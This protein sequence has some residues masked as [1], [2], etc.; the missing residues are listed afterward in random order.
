VTRPESSGTPSGRRTTALASALAAACV[1]L[2]LAGVVLHLIPGELPAGDYGA[3]WLTNSVAAVVIALPGALV[4]ARRP[5]NPLGWLLLGLAFAHGVTVVSREY[6]LHALV[7][8]SGLPFG[9][10]ALWLS[11][12]T[13]IDFPFFLPLFFLFPDGR[14]PSRR[15]A[16]VAAVGMAV[17]LVTTVWL[18]TFPGPMLESGS[19]TILNPLPWHGLARLYENRDTKV[20]WFL[21]A[22]LG[23][24]ILAMLMRA[25]AVVGPARRRIV[26]VALAAAVLA[27]EVGHE[28]LVSYSG[29]EYVAAGVVILFASAVAFAILR[30]GLYEIDFVVSRTVVYGGLT[31]ILGSSYV[32]LVALAGT[33]IHGRALGSLPAAVVVALLFAPVRMRLQRASD[34]LLFGERDD[35]YLVI[36]SLGE[37][38]ASDSPDALAALAHTVAGMLKLPYVAIEL[39]GDQGYELVAECGRLDGDPL[40]LPLIHGGEVTGRLTLGTRTRADRFTAKE[41]QLFADIARHVAV[42]AHSVQLTEELQRSREQLVAA[43]E[44]ERRRLRGDLH[45]GLGPTLAGIS[46]QIS[47]ARVLLSRDP[48]AADRL[49]GRLVN[50]TQG[51]IADIRRLIYALRPPALDELGLV[52]ALRMQGERF[53]GLD[54]LVRPDELESLPAAVEVAAYRIATEALTN[55][56]RH[57]GATRCTITMSVNGHF[58]LEICDDGKGLAAGWHAGVGISSIRERAAELGG[59]CTVAGNPNGGTRIF[60][61]LPLPA[62]D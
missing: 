11:G 53:P 46:L 23:V 55:V 30:Y 25:R 48:I 49:L 43:R 16:P 14:L 17:A 44:E 26:L 39:E 7:R 33:F 51:A 19:Q 20:L 45:D 2:G 21:L 52:P 60:T 3:W 41:L 59:T 34:R 42:T 38:D 10:A 54:V 56:A 29:E 27:G 12:W 58:D 4:A 18:A 15:W 24:G 40:V 57:A 62:A 28:D 32:G 9:Q 31:I 8:H 37:L 47:S 5:R 22:T 50:E 13:W 36:S 61:R 35:P 1:A 6:S